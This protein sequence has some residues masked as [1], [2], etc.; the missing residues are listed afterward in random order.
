MDANA[1]RQ[2]SG[3]MY[4]LGVLGGMDFPD[5]SAMAESFQWYKQS[6]ELGDALACDQV[7]NYY[8]NG[9]G[10]RAAKSCQL[11]S[12]A[13][14][15]S[16]VRGATDAQYFMGAAYR[17]GDS[18]P[19]DTESLLFW[20]QKAAAKNHPIALYDL[21]VYDL[22][23]RTNEASLTMASNYMCRTAQSGNR[24]AQFQCALSSFRGDGCSGGL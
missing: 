9:R 1:V 17:R 10:R 5:T 2:T 18:F 24:E 12:L 22:Q 3:S 11:L 20:Y 4:N 19:K 13:P 21:A 6:A 8:Y 16:K 15:S 14:R 7:A 23:F